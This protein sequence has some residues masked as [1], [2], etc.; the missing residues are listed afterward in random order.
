MHF[1]N[2]WYLQSF[3]SLETTVLKNKTNRRDRFCH[4]RETLKDLRRN[5]FHCSPQNHANI[6]YRFG[7]QR[8]C[9]TH[10]TS[11]CPKDSGRNRATDLCNNSILQ[12]QMGGA[13]KIVRELRLW[14][15]LYNVLNIFIAITLISSILV[16]INYFLH[17]ELFILLYE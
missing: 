2:I 1:T 14:L 12:S 5:T 4:S 8:E 11:F 10:E 6:V 7:W 13:L 9:W 16:L 3:C 15:F 17:S